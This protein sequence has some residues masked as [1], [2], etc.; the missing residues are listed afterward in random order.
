[1]YAAILQYSVYFAAIS[2]RVAK[3]FRTEGYEEQ[4]AF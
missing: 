1:M 3:N 2:Q 4:T